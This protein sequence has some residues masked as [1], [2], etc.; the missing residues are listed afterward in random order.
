VV[1]VRWL[2]L[3]SW[4]C[5]SA[6]LQWWWCGGGVGKWLCAAV[7]VVLCVSSLVPV[8]NKFLPDAHTCDN[9]H[10]PSPRCCCCSLSSVR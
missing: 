2:W 4:L 7:A 5:A 9:N 8:V 6:W 1:V 3:W 10:I